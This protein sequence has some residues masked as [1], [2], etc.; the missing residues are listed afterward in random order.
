MR[1][2]Y[3]VIGSISYINLKGREPIYNVHGRP[4]GR[5]TSPKEIQITHVANVLATD[6]ETAISIFKNNVDEFASAHHYTKM[7]G[8][9]FS[10]DLIAKF[11]AIESVALLAVGVYE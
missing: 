10:T 3:E 9:H 2:T 7:N 6:A 11:E 8:D 5:V 1:N 4:T